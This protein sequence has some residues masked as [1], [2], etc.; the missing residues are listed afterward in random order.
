[1]NCNNG[2]CFQ[3]AG[4]FAGV[5]DFAPYRSLADP[6]GRANA[7]SCRHFFISLESSAKFRPPASGNGTIRC[8][9]TF[10]NKS[11]KRVN[12]YGLDVE[13]YDRLAVEVTRSEASE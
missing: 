9:L 8:Y 10:H 3:R 4:F 6:S 11:D 2:R 1:V 7:M 5:G 12:E 13:E